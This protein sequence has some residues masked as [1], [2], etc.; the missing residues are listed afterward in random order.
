MW[1]ELLCSICVGEQVKAEACSY[2]LVIFIWFAP[3]L[4]LHH[5]FHLVCSSQS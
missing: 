3:L 1:V 5:L 2:D 4:D